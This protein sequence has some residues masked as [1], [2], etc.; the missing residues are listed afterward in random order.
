MSKFGI[1]FSDECLS[2]I[3]KGFRLWPRLLLQKDK[4]IFNQN[5]PCFRKLELLVKTLK[6]KENFA[7]NGSHKTFFT[8][9]QI[10][11]S[12]KV[13]LRE[14]IRSKKLYIRVASWVVK[15]HK[16]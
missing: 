10:S 6:G 4:M 5:I 2:L 12:L 3:L 11:L 8:F 9:Y 14:F 15:W 16:N 13:S 1:A 7:E